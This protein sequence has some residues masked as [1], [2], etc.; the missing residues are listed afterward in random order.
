MSVKEKPLLS[1][2]DLKT[3]FY[4]NKGTIRAVDGVSFSL[5]KGEILGLVGESGSGKTMTS[6]S[7]LGLVPS[8][9]KIVDGEIL[10]DGEDLLKKNEKEIHRLHELQKRIMQFQ[11][12]HSPI[13]SHS[14][15]RKKMSDM[16]ISD[17]PSK[18]QR[19][20]SVAA[21]RKPKMRK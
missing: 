7:I 8:P 11:R 21:L 13:W 9:G 1:V 5:R 2:K 20:K 18:T 14:D 6:L 10:F 19:Q 12:S 17:Y 4:T 15:H 3:Y 16:R